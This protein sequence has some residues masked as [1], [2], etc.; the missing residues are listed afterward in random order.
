MW[1]LARSCVPGVSTLGKLW[2]EKWTTYQDPI[3]R[4]HGMALVLHILQ[5]GIDDFKVKAFV[6]LAPT[7]ICF[8]AS[9]WWLTSIHDSRWRA[10]LAPSWPVSAEVVQALVHSITLFSIFLRC[11]WLF[12]D[13]ENKVNETGARALFVVVGLF[14]YTSLSLGNALALLNP[15]TK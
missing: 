1:S 14:S 4:A 5:S 12:Q 9:M 2:K 6:A 13:S 15:S 7:Q 3:F 11:Y 8:P 10:S